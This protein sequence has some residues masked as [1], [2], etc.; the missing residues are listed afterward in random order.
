MFTTPSSAETRQAQ[1][2]AAAS[3]HQTA[4]LIPSPFE[5]SGLFGFLKNPLMR[6]R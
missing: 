4:L 6:G 3:A 5:S 1:S 2:N